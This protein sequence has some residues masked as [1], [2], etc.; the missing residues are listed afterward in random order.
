M[1]LPQYH[2]VIDQTTE[3]YHFTSIGPNGRINKIVQFDKITDDPL[4]YNLALG[5]YNAFTKEID[6]EVV[7]N[8][9][10]QEKVFATFDKQ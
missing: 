6:D 7:S 5:D 10:D 8:N 1:N 2:F 3:L 9:R 4:V